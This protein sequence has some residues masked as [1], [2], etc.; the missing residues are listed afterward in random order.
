MINRRFPCPS[1]G[2]PTKIGGSREQ[3][4]MLR[5]AYA[6]CTN[7]LCSASWQ[8]NIEVAAVCSP[9]SKLFAANAPRSRDVALEDVLPDLAQ[10][11][12]VRGKLTHSREKAIEQCIHYLFEKSGETINQAQAWLLA[13]QA[14]AA[15]DSRQ[16]P[17][18]QVN[19]EHCSSNAVIVTLNPSD[20]T[21]PAQQFVVSL[22]EL[23]D[24]IA[25]RN[26]QAQE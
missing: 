18:W 13:A 16:Y 12:V 8:L 20:A 3:S 19:V 1:C 4:P 5:R 11:F 17:L 10:E 2:A 15:Y 6:Q 14:V 21:T 9:P 24:L 22:R 25:G 26:V 23:I 7:Y